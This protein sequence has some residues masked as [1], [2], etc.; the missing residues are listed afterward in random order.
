MSKKYKYQLGDCSDVFVK[1]TRKSFQVRVCGEYEGND[2]DEVEDLHHSA[3]IVSFN[4][5]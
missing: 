5:F 1:K 2:Y 3:S 4:K